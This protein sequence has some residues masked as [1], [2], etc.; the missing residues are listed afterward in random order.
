MRGNTLIAGA[1]IL[2]IA[3]G[4]FGADL[5][6]KELPHQKESGAAQSSSSSSKQ[7][8]PSEPVAS[9]GA[10]NSSAM[11][12]S[13][14]IPVTSSG[15][16]SSEYHVVK[17]GVST[18]KH[19]GVDVQSVLDRQQ[20]ITQETAEASFLSFVVADKSAVKTWVLL[21]NNDR[22]FLFSWIDN[23]DA[24]TIMS[25]LKQAL[26]EQF[27]GK[28]TDLVDETRT[29]DSGPPVDV[30]SFTDPTLSPEKIMFLR[31]RT[32]LYEIHIAKN[33]SDALDA[34]VAELSK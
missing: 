33:G 23:D 30:L 3:G 17:K 8:V 20:L 13:S 11:P 14:A 18:K 12:A 32:R 24:K 25:S 26:S 9:S 5:W 34:L 2:L 31:V 19:A 15:S 4:L 16:S 29:Q 22:A 7:S 6:L 1:V 10:T 21:K 28:L 27:S